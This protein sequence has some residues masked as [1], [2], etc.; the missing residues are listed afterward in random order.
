[1]N[2]RQDSSFS[3]KHTQW[4]LNAFSSRQSVTLRQV[5]SLRALDS[6]G[7]ASPSVRPLPGKP[8]AFARVPTPLRPCQRACISPD[9]LTATDRMTTVST[10]Q[11]GTRSPRRPSG[12]ERGHSC[13]GHTQGSGWDGGGFLC[14]GPRSGTSVSGPGL[15][16]ACG[17][18]SGTQPDGTPHR[19]V[20]AHPD[21]ERGPH[22]RC[23]PD[24]RC[25]PTSSVLLG[26]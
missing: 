1:M 26:C 8:H 9:T 4:R 21:P 5:T 24:G 17:H 11:R 19:A 15:V 7:R 14:V 10:L 25:V 20:C 2:K 18:P 23:V 22:G 3:H 12:E 13:P 16:G 6:R